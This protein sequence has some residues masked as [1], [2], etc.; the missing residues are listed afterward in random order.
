M[1]FLLEGSLH[2]LDVISVGKNEFLT[3]AD[4]FNKMDPMEK[5]ALKVIIESVIVRSRMKVM[6]KEK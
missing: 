3:Y 5:K 4:D 1:D 6:I 2:S